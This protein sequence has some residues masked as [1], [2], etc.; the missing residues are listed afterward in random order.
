MAKTLK[1][2]TNKG[3]FSIYVDKDLMAKYAKRAQVHE[4]SVN[5]EVEKSL[6]KDI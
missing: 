3:K 4:R 2:P 6:T 1:K 5:Y